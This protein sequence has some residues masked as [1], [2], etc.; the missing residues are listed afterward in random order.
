MGR[1]EEYY[2]L[3]E[4]NIDRFRNLCVNQS[5]LCSL[6]YIDQTDAAISGLQTNKIVFTSASFQ[7]Q[8][9]S[10]IQFHLFPAV[11]GAKA[12]INLLRRKKSTWLDLD[13]LRRIISRAPTF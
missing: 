5:K 2:I 8:V 3:S 13:R 4:I 12:P 9:Q 6:W 7:L 1:R 11:T 10:L